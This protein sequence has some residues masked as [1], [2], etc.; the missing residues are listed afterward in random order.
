MNTEIRL[1]DRNDAASF[2][3]HSFRRSTVL[4]VRKS[5]SSPLQTRLQND[6]PL[7]ILRRILEHA[8]ALA[9]H[10]LVPPANVLAAAMPC[11]H[12]FSS[13]TGTQALHLG[14]AAL[15]WGDRVKVC[16]EPRE[17][18]SLDLCGCRGRASWASRAAGE[19]PPVAGPRLGKRRVGGTGQHILGAPH[20]TAPH[21][22]PRR[23]WR[24]WHTKMVDT[25][26]RARFVHHGHRAVNAWNCNCECA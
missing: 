15:L 5:G 2:R 24:A 6:Q 20:R 18:S 13:S 14:V 23:L 7:S 17:K 19:S 11:S 10:R 8:P 22:S 21:R 26:L 16:S 3:A 9:A 25:S 4:S 1:A 12:E